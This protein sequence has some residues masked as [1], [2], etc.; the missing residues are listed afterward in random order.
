MPELPEVET[1]VR[2]L[3]GEMVGR[4]FVL[5]WVSRPG[6]LRFPAAEVFTAA[7]P[8]RSVQEVSRRGKYIVCRLDSDEALV[9][10]LGM[11]GHL[12]V[13]DEGED[14]VLHT[15]LRAILDDG[16]ELRFDDARRFGRIL[17]G[18][19]LLLLE[20]GL[21]PALGVEPLSD[22][23]TPDCLDGLIRRTTRRLKGVLLDQSMIAG[24]GSIY[25]DEACHLAGVRPTRRCHRLTRRERVALHG[26]IQAVLRKA[27]ANRGTTFDDYRDLWNARGTNQEALQVYG[28]GGEPCLSCGATLRKTVVSGRSSVYCPTCQR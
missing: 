12:R 6:V 22:D 19:W 26:A 3:R 10:H 21:V 20:L 23:F 24:L 8:G 16:Q 18:P 14:P 5:A 28:R 2:D 27:V 25:I 15:H 17:L 7:L 11:T 13:V 9:F 1:I 4:R